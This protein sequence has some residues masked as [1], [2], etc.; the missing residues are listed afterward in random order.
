VMDRR[1]TRRFGSAVSQSDILDI[2]PTNPNVTVVADLT[3]GD[4]LPSGKY[5]CFILTQTLQFID[6]PE[7][8]LTQA[9]RLLRPGGVLL[10]T[11]PSVSRLDRRLTDYWRFTTASCQVLFRCA[12]NEENLTV[13]SHGNVL[14]AM[15]FLTGLAAEELSPRELDTSDELFP[16][17]I[18]IKAVRPLQDRD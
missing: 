7:A 5:D 16:V 17:I 12:F 1:Y 14:A 13:E 10:A 2:D 6:R 3:V 4:G 15:A 11:V 8:A 9:Y 18:T